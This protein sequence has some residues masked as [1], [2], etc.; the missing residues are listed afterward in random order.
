M[1]SEAIALF[2]LC[3][4]CLEVGFW[5]L[6][7]L[8]ERSFFTVTSLSTPH[9][10]ALPRSLSAELR[11]WLCLFLLALLSLAFSKYCVIPTRKFWKLCSLTW[12]P[13]SQWFW[14][15]E[16]K[17][18]VSVE[19]RQ[20]HSDH[21]MAVDWCVACTCFGPPIFVLLVYFFSKETFLSMLKGL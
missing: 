8:T 3:S 16:I 19:H 11:F 12:L 5:K 17:L 18:K 6:H 15:K 10:T 2:Q 13:S 1:S 14:E 20:V 21:Y 9:C 4:L 7:V